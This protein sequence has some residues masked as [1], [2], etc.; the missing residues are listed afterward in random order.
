MQKHKK[1]I[2]VAVEGNIRS[3]AEQIFRDDPRQRVSFNMN[4]NPSIDDNSFSDNED[5]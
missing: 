4:Y 5:T 2:P 1:T 3:S